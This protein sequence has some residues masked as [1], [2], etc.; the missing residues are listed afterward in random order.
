MKK[1]ITIAVL[2]L[3]SLTWRM[4]AMQQPA[5]AAV[6]EVILQTNDGQEVSMSEADARLFGTIRDVIDECGNEQPIPLSNVSLVVLRRLLAD[7][8]W[9]RETRIGRQAHE[10]EEQ[11]AERAAGALPASGYSVD[12]LRQ[13]RE[14]FEAAR[15]L[16][17]PE[18]MERY[19]RI[20]AGMLASDQSLALL[21]NNDSACIALINN[22][23]ADDVFARWICK[24][25]PH[26]WGQ[27]LVLQDTS[28]V[29]SASFSPN[30]N[31]VV[32]ACDE[33]TAKIWD[34]NRGA[35]LH[36]LQ[37]HTDVVRSA[38]FS[39]DGSRVVT[40]S[41]DQTAKIWNANNGALLHTLQAPQ[42]H[43]WRVNS[44]SFSPD[45]S[46]VV[47]ASSDRTA[48]IWDANSGGLLRTLQWAQG[49]TNWYDNSINSASFSWD[50]NRVVT[51]SNDRT[52]KIWNANSGEVLRTLRGHNA[53]VYSASFSRDGNRVVTASVDGTARIWNAN[54]GDLL[55]RLGEDPEGHFGWVPVYSASFSPDGTRVVTASRDR[56]AK[57]WNANSGDLLD[58]LH[59]HTDLVRSASFSPDGTR[60]L[61]ASF[62]GTARIWQSTWTDNFD[63]AL[64]IHML[65][66]AQ[67]NNKP[68]GW[69]TGWGRMV[70]DTYNFHDQELIKQ[71]FPQ[72]L[73]EK[74]KERV[75]RLFK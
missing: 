13:A 70:M 5:K 7:I 60:V 68:V 9:A 4:G 12:G 46:R 63:Q 20:V 31:R 52:A 43:A 47:T 54:N 56:M 41:N 24:H 26:V 53:A 27:Q 48:K 8:P 35:L 59:G 44:A 65:R 30:G 18:L 61:T 19:A 51:A 10:T 36:T 32:T 64:F 58:T 57:I 34:V 3:G 28:A 2:A 69:Q 33:G 42:G 17:S 14:N 71:A 55:H 6:R 39:P 50:G 1:M 25:L 73:M 62:D 66:W 37:G 38:S 67:R 49:N 21:Y 75:G 15:Y 29:Y 72:S 11:C 45:G 40:A 16:L 74:L 23:G 22:I